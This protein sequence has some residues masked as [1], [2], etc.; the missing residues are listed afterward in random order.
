MLCIL[1]VNIDECYGQ[2]IIMQVELS[3]DLVRVS[4]SV[5]WLLVCWLPY[6]FHMEL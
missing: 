1:T 6:F 5:K 4:F 2:C 3:N